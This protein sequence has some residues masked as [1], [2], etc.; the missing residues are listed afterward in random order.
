MPPRPTSPD[1]S[2]SRASP[3]SPTN[4]ENPAHSPPAPISSPCGASYQRERVKK[5]EN[6]AYG[7]KQGDLAACVAWF[8]V[9]PQPLIASLVMVVVVVVV[10]VIKYRAAITS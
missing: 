1:S 3:T 10:V 7:G 5:M 9:T 6:R 2:T 8:K 4:P